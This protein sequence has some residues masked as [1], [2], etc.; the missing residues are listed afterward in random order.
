MKCQTGKENF[1]SSMRKA[2]RAH[3]GDTPLALG[4][5]FC[6]VSGKAKVHVMVR[7][8]NILQTVYTVV[9]HCQRR[10][11]KVDLWSSRLL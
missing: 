6:I 11:A 9:G 2:L 7:G 10:L 3:Y 1:V 5:V 8:C 4:G